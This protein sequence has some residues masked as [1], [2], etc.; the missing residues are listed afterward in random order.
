[1]IDVMLM[2]WGS[3][4]TDCLY[5]NAILLCRRWN[6]CQGSG[7]LDFDKQDTLGLQVY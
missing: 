5:R 4:K 7:R 2:G 6:E 1:L 3:K